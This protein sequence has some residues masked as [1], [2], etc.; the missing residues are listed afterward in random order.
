M[1]EHT[2]SMFA[3]VPS[4]LLGAAAGIASDSLIVG[5]LVWLGA[6]FFCWWLWEVT[7]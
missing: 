4:A 2:A 1:S 5:G 7:H 3:L 6:Y